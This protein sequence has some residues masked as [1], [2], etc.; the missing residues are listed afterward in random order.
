MVS[1]LEKAIDNLY[2]CYAP[3]SI[4]ALFISMILIDLAPTKCL[5]GSLAKEC[6]FYKLDSS[7]IYHPL[8]IIN[9]LFIIYNLLYLYYNVVLKQ[10]VVG[11]AVK[12][13]Y[14]K[15]KRHYYLKGKRQKV[16]V[17]LFCYLTALALSYFRF[18]KTL[19]KAIY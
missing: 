19:A 13:I 6:L 7:L 18:H 17:L 8:N 3:V 11:R 14:G 15:V 16:S 9:L 2:L 12:K 1:K 10:D 4:F 5:F